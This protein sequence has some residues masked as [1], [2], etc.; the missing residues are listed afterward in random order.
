MSWTMQPHCMSP[1]LWQILYQM[2]DCQWLSMRPHACRR[3]TSIHACRPNVVNAPGGVALGRG[4]P[5]FGQ[6]PGSVPSRQIAPPPPPPPPPPAPIPH[7]HAVSSAATYPRNG[8]HCIRGPRRQEEAVHQ[9][10]QEEAQGPEWETSPIQQVIHTQEEGHQ[11]PMGQE[12]HNPQEEAIQAVVQAAAVHLQAQHLH[13]SQEE[14]A[15]QVAARQ[16]HLQAYLIRQIL[17][18]MGSLRQIK[19][20]IAEAFITFQLQELQHLGYAADP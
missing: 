2:P 16:P 9:M 10:V 13:S 3:G 8:H 7:G 12:E 18:S 19:K 15:I 17:R 6:S 5:G 14:Q 4:P 11:G 20:S 1:S